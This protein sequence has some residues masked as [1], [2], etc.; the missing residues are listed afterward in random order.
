MLALMFLLV[1]DISLRKLFDRPILSAYEVVMFM[2]AIVVAT[3]LSYTAMEKGHIKIELVVSK[4]PKRT[5][6]I[7]DGITS[8][9][10]LGLFALIAQQIIVRANGLR[11]EGLTSPIL[12]LPV[13]PFYLVV[14]LGFI[15]LCLVLLVHALNSFMPRGRE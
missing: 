13:Y 4:L 15:L 10:S 8:F 2:M 9:L 14:A 12:H 6:E 11:L 5:R 7:L 1:A 3:A